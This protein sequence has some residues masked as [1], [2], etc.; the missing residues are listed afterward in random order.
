MAEVTK[1]RVYDTITA[2]IDSPD[3][4]VV[5]DEAYKVDVAYCSRVGKYRPNVKRPI[6]VTFQ[7]RQGEAYEIK[8]QISKGSIC[9]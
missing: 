5:L 3:G 6:T 2:T 7:R 4:N 9:Q 1:Q 8:K